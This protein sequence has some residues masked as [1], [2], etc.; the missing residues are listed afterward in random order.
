MK[1]KLGNSSNVTLIYTETLG[2]KAAAKLLKRVFEQDF[3][4]D[5]KLC[6]RQMDVTDSVKLNRLLGDYIKI[7]RRTLQAGDPSYRCSCSDRW[8]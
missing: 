7:L 8:V 2:G 1:G 3:S 6:P 5:V 4:A